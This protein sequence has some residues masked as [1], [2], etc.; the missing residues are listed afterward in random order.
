M[1][2]VFLADGFEETEALVTVDFLRRA[3]LDV[4]TVAVAVLNSIESNVIRGAH[5]IR[6]LCDWAPNIDDEISWEPLEA[7]ILPGGMP[8]AANLEVSGLV[9]TALEYAHQNGLLIA[10]I[11]AAPSIL[12]H[13]DLLE[14]KR[15]VC[16]PG[17]E[18]D[19][20][21]GGASVMDEYVVEDGQFITAKGAGCTIDFAEAIAARFAGKDKAQEIR[22]VMQTPYSLHVL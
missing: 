14:G 13:L 21:N 18:D 20:R 12:A 11:C 16:F 15:A 19:L 10:A 17:Y 4:Q 9:Q 8:G 5:N 6:V 3:G 2:A 7:V 1:I 22:E